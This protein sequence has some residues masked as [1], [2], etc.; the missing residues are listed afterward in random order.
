MTLLVLREPSS[1]TTTLGCLFVDGVWFAFTCED[2]VREVPGQPVSAWKVQGQTAIPAGTY[3]VVLSH[4]PR[5][6]RTLPEVRSVPGFTG[7]RIHA[8]NTAADSEGCLLVGFE[9]GAERI[10]KS[11]PALEALMA[12]LHEAQ[13]R[14]ESMRVTF[15]N[16]FWL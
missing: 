7:V 8:G 11:R 4:S 14:R 5:F 12:R 3:P 9:R 2:V 1:S 15:R 16:G 13:T 10:L 6:G